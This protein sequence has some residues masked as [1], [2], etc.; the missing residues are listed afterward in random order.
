MGTIVIGKLESGTINKGQNLLLMPN[1]VIFNGKH[2]IV[3][4]HQVHVQVF[5]Y[6]FPYKF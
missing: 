6:R 3:K 5:Y 1:R 4:Y 2:Y